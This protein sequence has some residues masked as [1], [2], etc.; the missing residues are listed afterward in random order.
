MDCPRCSYINSS[1]SFTCRSC[2]QRLQPRCRECGSDITRDAAFCPTCGAAL[3]PL[4]PGGGG[5]DAEPI[6][7]GERRRAT[8]LFSDVSG[9]TAL[10]E[11]LDPEDVALVMS[12][13]KDAATR[14]VEAYGGTVNQFVGDEVMSL[15]G[16]PLAHDDDPVRAVQAAL[17]LHA[18]MRELATE[19][20]PRIGHHLS[21]HTAANTG[22]VVAQRR[23]RREG[24]FGVTGDVI[25]TCARLVAVAGRDEIVV[26]ESTHGSIEPYFATE[27][28]GRVELRG[29]AESVQ[30][31]RVLGALARSMF[32][33]AQRRGLSRMVGRVDELERFRG[34]LEA[35]SAGQSGLVTVF[36]EPGIGKSRL[37]HEFDRLARAGGYQVHHARCEP[38][39]SVAP[40]A[41]FVQLLR[42]RLGLREQDAPPPNFARQAIDRIRALGPEL[43]PHL[44]TL[45]HLLSLRSEE[46]AIPASQLGET[47]RQ[48]ILDALVATLRALASDAPVIL[49]LE[50]WHWADQ[51]SELALRHVLRELAFLRCLVVVNYRSHIEPEWGE[52]A[53]AI[54]LRPLVSGDAEALVDSLLRPDSLPS[55]LRREIILRTA[56]NPFFIEEVCRAISESR[57][58]KP[59]FAAAGAWD[60]SVFVPDTVEAVVR[61][62]IDRLSP[63]AR[64]VLRVASVLGSEFSLD[65]LRRVAETPELGP[66]LARLQR[67]GL[68]QDTR[69]GE[70]RVCRF[71]HFTIQ[72]VAYETLLL[73]RRRTLHDR[74]GAALEEQFA[75]HLEARFEEL[76]HHFALG[77]NKEKAVFYLECA[78][79]KAA[80]TFSLEQAR[81][82][83]SAAVRSLAELEQNPERVSKRIDLTFAWGQAGWY[84]PT[85]EQIDAL[86]RAHQLALELG[87]EK[88]ALRA[89]YFI[90]WL[91]YTMGD[92]TGAIHYLERCMERVD[93]ADHRMLSQL[94]CNLGQNLVNQTEYDRALGYLEQGIELRKRSFPQSWRTIGMA[95]A[96]SH[97]GLV[98]ADR[99]DF[100]RSALCIDEAISF[101]GSR[102]HGSA[103]AS[104][105]QVRAMATVLKGDW[106]TCLQY[107]ALGSQVAKA[108]GAPMNRAM[109]LCV[110]GWC[111][112][113]GFDQK[114]GAQALLEGIRQM[115]QQGVQLG[116]SLYL[117]FAAEALARLNDLERAA[118]FA[119]LALE[120]RSHGDRLGEAAGTRAM[121][122]ALARRGDWSRGIACFAGARELARAKQSP[123]EELLCDLVLAE[124][125]RDRGEHAESSLHAERARAGFALLGMP[126]YENRARAL[127]GGLPST[128]SA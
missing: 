116:A 90:A 43:E 92:S 73:G 8:V 27:P 30:A 121:G 2:G 100:V 81:H 45:L 84:G 62:R 102:W 38:W 56:G 35:L 86:E 22:L 111:L 3:T 1:D 99:G 103:L 16:V 127:L 39:G 61:A 63:S 50:D 15:F 77:N 54:E 112:F 91:R 72:K 78:G 14:I 44:A 12:R 98:H 97:I 114:D 40:Y 51:A 125:L 60:E 83:Y 101:I 70:E 94:H 29:K 41:P 71:R 21:L 123:R 120:R 79:N 115:D 68:V 7:A 67:A 20:A 4:P 66:E 113:M 76:A 28:L 96:L 118:D 122:L 46:H 106:D 17:S 57:T 59:G 18:F 55:D 25:N 89:I 11:K 75:G 19:L 69:P 109:A 24:T 58:S 110:E 33:V 42:D 9:Y 49:F 104:L 119:K 37:F 128:A 107:T 108:I 34:C 6:R 47:L 117:A 23:D 36:G 32:E 93:P 13:I 5:S 74:A 124:C 10:N 95:Y 64:E 52:G 48:A 88:R 82:H 80:S 26:G 65:A 85:Q 53:H 87:D 126:W 31:Y 105:N